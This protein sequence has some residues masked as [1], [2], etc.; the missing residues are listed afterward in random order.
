[1]SSPVT[2]TT[3]STSV[4]SKKKPPKDVKGALKG[5]DFHNSELT[6]PRP[7]HNIPSGGLFS[8]Y[9]AV[10]IAAPPQVVYDALLDVGDWKQWN[11]FVYNVKIT[12]NPNPH[13]TGQRSHTRMTGG[14][15][16]IFYRNISYDPPKQAESRQVV[17]L[18]EKLK[19]AK[20]G[21]N[22][23]C[24]T[25]I[26]WQLD[27]A[28]ISTPGFLLKCERINEIEEAADGTTIYR[29]WEVFAGP[30][31]RT[32][33]TNFEQN[34]RYRLQD[35]TRDLKQWCEK[36]YTQGGAEPTTAE[37]TVGKSEGGFAAQTA[38]GQ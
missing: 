10:A 34:W 37:G 31:A 13:G 23:P 25:R 1:M 19:L 3:T 4:T 20:D 6:G 27:N 33:R 12:K 28:A 38:V 26:R 36:K 35:W 18:V 5:A 15:C 22:A 29:T 30:L 16:M 24:V 14:T 8:A 21:H 7:T 11:T 32:V 9:S 2:P 17:T